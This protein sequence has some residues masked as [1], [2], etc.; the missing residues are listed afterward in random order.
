MTYMLVVGFETDSPADAKQ[1]VHE[2]VLDALGRVRALDACDAVSFAFARHPETGERRGVVFTVY[3]DVE[4][5]AEQERP[6]WEQYQETGLV[7]DWEREMEDDYEGMV[8]TLG[9]GPA[10]LH[11][12][13][14]DLTGEMAEL[15]LERFDDLGYT[16][17]A[18][19]TYPEADCDAGP[20]GWWNVLHSLTLQLN[21]SYREEIDAY[22]YGIEHTLRNIAEHEDPETAEETLDEL[23]AEIEGM[24]EEV[25]DGRLFTPSD[26]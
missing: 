14:S 3:G 22:T 16:P 12:E 21:Y 25:T 26:A 10:E 20:I 24:R 4:T 18:V 13:L 9:E 2:Y 19:D 23:I 7:T 8:E 1:F 6:Q 11:P 15:A 5:I 17:A